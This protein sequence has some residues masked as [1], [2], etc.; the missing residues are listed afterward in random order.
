[1]TER[2][3]WGLR[4]PVR[5]CR[6]E[7]TWSSGRVGDAHHDSA[8]LEFRP[9][10][11]LVSHWHQNHDGSTWKT[12][13]EYDDLGRLVRVRSDDG[14]SEERV[15]T[16]EY[17]GEGRLSHVVE[18]EH[19]GRGRISE[20]CEYA[21]GRKQKTYCIDV[22]S[23][24]P[25]THYAWGIDGSDTAVAAPNA[26]TIVTVYNER[27]Q[28]LQAMLLDAAGLLLVRA[29]FVYDG[30]G[31]LV[32]ERVMRTVDALPP[33]I[34]AQMNPAELE[35]VRRIM[36]SPSEPARILHRYDE[37]G[38]RVETRSCLFGLI[39]EHRTT[40]VYNDVG[41]P[42][43]EVTEDEHREVDVGDSGELTERQDSTT[44]HRSEARFDYE[45][46]GRGNWVKKAVEGSSIER[47][48]L[49]YYD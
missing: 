24:L 30:A 8:I 13:H 26:A 12:T 29:E 40:M 17:D 35:A 42:A 41:D 6:L 15:Q 14:A 2:E 45:Y 43:E 19:D 33:D 27:D 4:G 46:D 3:R 25:N 11:T 39:G 47:R 18:H 38:R 7:R 34:R 49:V 28:P 10:G 31:Q 23:Q 16:Y 37:R 5:T 32:E 9:D 1:M 36:G 22:T 48:T 44:R 20:S 21:G